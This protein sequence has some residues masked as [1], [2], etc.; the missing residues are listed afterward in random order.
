[1]TDHR[2]APPED[3][4]ALA[5]VDAAYRAAR[6]AQQHTPQAQA[7]TARRRA[8]VL[9]AVAAVPRVQPQALPPVVVE[10]A[11]QPRPAATRT[12]PAWWQGVAAACVLVSSALLVV[13]LQQDPAADPQESRRPTLEAAADPK[14]QSPDARD[15]AVAAPA[16]T[17]QAQGAAAKAPRGSAPGADQSGPLATPAPAAVHAN[18]ATKPAPNATAKTAA[19]DAAP[20]VVAEPARTAKT[21]TAPAPVVTTPTAGATA[22]PAPAARA[23]PAAP[24]AEAGPAAPVAEGA[25]ARP[26]APPIAPPMAPPIAPPA[27]AAAPTPS[28][29]A[30]DNSSAPPTLEG[31]A[32]AKRA[33]R[34]AARDAAPAGSLNGLASSRQ[35]P[36]ALAAATPLLSAAAAQDYAALDR[37]LASGASPDAE[38]DRNGRTALMLA[39]LRDDARLVRWLLDHGADPRITDRDGGS[40]LDHARSRGNEAVLQALGLR[41]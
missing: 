37:L 16:S 4:D 1:M 32:I 14:A 15:E 38:R 21:A 34:P 7:D 18:G 27:P 17:D 3:D 39:V 35:A 24:S 30:A 20:P 33:V 19:R 5:A 11:P 9:A 2:N 26:M 12:M 36:A 29:T 23:F 40:S 22:A 25:A 8:A 13:R 10:A 6:D 41:P 28:P 31:A